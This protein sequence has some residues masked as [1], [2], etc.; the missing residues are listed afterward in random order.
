MAED[1]RAR[2]LRGL[3]DGV[4][5]GGP[6]EEG[7]PQRVLAEIRLREASAERLIGWVQ[8]AIVLFFAT[9]YAIAPRAEGSSGFNFVPLALGAY[10]LF[11]VVRLA[12][13]YRVELPNW[14]LLV[15]I[16]VDMALLVGLI[17]SFHIQY[18]Q[19]P[20][21]YL[22]A[23][24]LMYVFIF[25][26]LRALRFDPRFVLTTGLVAVAGWLA[27]VAY[28]VLADM[29]G[30]RVTRNYVEYLTGNAILIGAELDK[31]MVI[32]TVTLVLAVALYRGREVLYSAIRERSAAADLRRFFAPEAAAS[33]TGAD[34]VL[35]AGEGHAREAAVLY[36]DV[37]GF[38]RTAAG[39]PPQVVMR[40]L[41]L[42]QERAVRAIEARGGRVDKFLGDG[43]LATF[44]ALV[45][46][47][48]FA[49]DAVEAARAVVD[50]LDTDQPAF[51]AAGW[52]EAFRVGVALACGPV[53]VGVVGAADRLEFTVIGDAV[54]RA[55]KLEDANKVE[56]SRALTDRASFELALGQGYA[57]PPGEHR[58]AR[59]VAGL[60]G[61]LDLVVLA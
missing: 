52:P 12:L 39:L 31:T 49:A 7:I 25:I 59:A 1:K 27:L 57:G 19:H 16:G 50:G 56:R 53:T 11:T 41:G 2:R 24:T 3:L 36:V 32:L 48:R 43:I 4:I 45:P 8:L 6:S 42:Y 17:F 30:M 13:S 18:G 20:T 10:F 29:G 21:F 9:L 61:P 26:A 44:G 51:A 47:A 46:S 15:S 35:R 33:I 34:T 55:A 22:K 37:R 5:R 54:N 58:P 23:P 28:A 14:Y 60:S 40:V 38:T